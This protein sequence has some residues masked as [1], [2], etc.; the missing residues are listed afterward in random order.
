MVELRSV[1][2]AVHFRDG[3][4]GFGAGAID[5]WH[6]QIAVAS[7]EIDFDTI[8]PDSWP[9]ATRSRAGE[10]RFESVETR[11]WNVALASPRGAV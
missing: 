1:A 11:S 8:G 5:F 4:T 3:L 10:T 6:G 7:V 9:V 2:V